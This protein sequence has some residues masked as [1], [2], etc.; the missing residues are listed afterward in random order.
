MRSS[1]VS[2]NGVRC[3]GDEYLVPAASR[4]S[5]ARCADRTLHR[6]AERH[7]A[8]DHHARAHQQ[9]DRQRDFAGDENAPRAKT[10]RGVAS[11]AFLQG[12]P[13]IAVRA[14]SAGNV[15][16][17]RPGAPRM[18][19]HEQQHAHVDRDLVGARQSDWPATS[20]RQ[21]RPTCANRR[22]AKTARRSGA[23][24]LRRRAAGTRGHDPRPWRI[25]WRAP[26][27][28]RVHAPGA[29]WRRSRRR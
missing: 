17:R 11:P 23:P 19:H 2:K 9:N 8:P 28:A 27:G 16:A 12:V 4:A 29:D 22:P 26:C 15:P 5:S 25:G 1:A 21:L 3:A 14:R 24:A 13:Q 20:C 6:P 10:K 7:Q 18:R